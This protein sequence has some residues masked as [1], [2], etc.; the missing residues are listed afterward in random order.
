MFGRNF[1]GKFNLQIRMSAEISDAWKSGLGLFMLDYHFV[2][3][4]FATMSLFLYTY[5]T[6]KKCYRRQQKMKEKKTKF[7][8]WVFGLSNNVFFSR[9]VDH[10]VISTLRTVWNERT[11]CI[12]SFYRQCEDV[13][14]LA[15]RPLDVMR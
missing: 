4:K 12:W 6:T 14:E 13:S 5:T 8:M 3:C 1:H 15:I 2:F 10:F 11:A 7:S 9:L